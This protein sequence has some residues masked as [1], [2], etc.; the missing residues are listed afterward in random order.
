M[1]C[2]QCKE[3]KPIYLNGLCFDCSMTLTGAVPASPEERCPLIV[4]EEDLDAGLKA[5][6][7]LNKQGFAQMPDGYWMVTADHMKKLTAQVSHLSEQLDEAERGDL[8][9][10]RHAAA[11]VAHLSSMLP[12]GVR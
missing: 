12:G 2:Q 5:A 9:K 6:R 10:V 8:G 7:L 3:P 11:S 1:I 4:F